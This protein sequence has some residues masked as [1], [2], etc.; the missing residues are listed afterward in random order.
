MATDDN[1]DADD[2]DDD[3]VLFCEDAGSESV[4]LIAAHALDHAGSASVALIAAHSVVPS[5]PALSVA[6]KGPGDD[7][8]CY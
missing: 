4:S 7:Y 6:L 2:D 1:E 3:D 5:S 8:Y